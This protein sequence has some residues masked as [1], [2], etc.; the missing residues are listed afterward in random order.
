MKGCDTATGW[1]RVLCASDAD[2]ASSGTG[3]CDPITWTCTFCDNDGDCAAA[4]AGT[5]TKC[6]SVKVLFGTTKMCV[7]CSGDADCAGSRLS[8]CDA[9]EGTCTRCK[10]DFECCVSAGSC[11]LSCNLQT[12]E[13]ECT[14][15]LQC[16]TAMGSALWRCK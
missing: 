10:Y 14:S 15:D 3:R 2:C 16:S 9:S 7:G 5:T 11:P 4:G 8:G 12:G 6:A 1:C 13:C